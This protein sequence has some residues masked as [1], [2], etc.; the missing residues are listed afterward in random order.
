MR[1]GHPVKFWHQG[2]EVDT[3]AG[4]QYRQQFLVACPISP[5][6]FC[7]ELVQGGG[8]DAVEAV[9]ET[10]FQLDTQ[11]GQGVQLPNENARDH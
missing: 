4:G 9:V 3:V 2:F 8:G 6:K 7:F 5:C 1:G 11:G 10:R